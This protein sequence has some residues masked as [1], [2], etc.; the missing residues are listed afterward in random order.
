MMYLK[1]MICVRKSVKYVCNLYTIKMCVQS[2][3]LYIPQDPCYTETFVAT[4]HGQVLVAHAG[5]KSKPALLTYH[6]LGLNYIS[7]FQAFFNYPELREVLEHFCIFHVNAPGQEEG[8][9]P[10]PESF[11]YPTMEILAEQ[12]LDVINH[13]NITK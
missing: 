5:D 2:S 1:C 11:E 4:N 3:Y 6:D 7:N 13:F 10:L 9:L 12:V 8:A